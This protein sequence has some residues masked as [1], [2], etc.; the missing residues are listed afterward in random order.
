MN[1][2]RTLLSA[3]LAS[4]ALLSACSLRPHYRDVV[5][6]GPSESAAGQ[7]VALRVVDAKTN[8]PVPGAR[9]LAGE[10][11]SRLSATSDADGLVTLQVS[12]EL[13]RENPLVEVVLPAGVRSYRLELVPSGQAPAPEATPEAPATSEAPAT[14]EAPA[15]P[16][17]PETPA[18]T[19]PVAP[20]S[21]DAGT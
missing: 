17:A 2:R 6:P 11:R 14:P 15:V 1:L 5:R 13:L 7:T 16:A 4:T 10:T 19:A 3:V 9:V 8:R 21:P 20:A 12:N 18:G